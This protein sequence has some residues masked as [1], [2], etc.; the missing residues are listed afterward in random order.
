MDIKK[1]NQRLL[2]ILGT[3]ATLFLLVG[4]IV[5]ISVSIAEYYRYNSGFTEDGILSDER[6]EELQKEKKRE[7]I[8]SYGQPRLIDT[9]SSIYIVPVSHK[10]LDNAED[11]SGLLSANY[12]GSSSDYESNDI[13]YS[14]QVYGSYNN[15]IIYTPKSEQSK[16]IFN[17]RV[18]FDRIESQYFSD[19]IYLIMTVAEEDTYKDGVVNLEDFKSLFVYS[20]NGKKLRKISIAGLDVNDYKFIYGT[21]DL[22]VS[23]GID[24]NKDGR[25]TPF[26][27]PTIIKKYSL[28]SE[29]MLDIVDIE[30]QENL[31]K[32][33][34]GSPTNDL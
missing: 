14:S 30:T 5:F 3:V 31:Q 18:N 19:E 2:A 6:I 9:L 13:R 33:L 17:S 10:S 4:L 23:F 16:K 32:T 34:E 29:R 24:K 8:I 22:I 15:V 12:S 1:Y 26:N 20:L 28:E 7:Q 21:K 27:E 25:F 11:I